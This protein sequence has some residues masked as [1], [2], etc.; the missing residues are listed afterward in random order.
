MD[1]RRGKPVS[2]KRKQQS[3]SPQNNN[4]P[5]LKTTITLASKQQSPSHQNN[6]H[7]SLK[8]TITLASNPY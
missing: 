2:T 8:S 6:N 4:H 1:L 3:P 5:R 7:P